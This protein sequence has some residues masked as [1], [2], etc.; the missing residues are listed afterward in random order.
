MSEASSAAPAEQTLEQALAEMKREQAE[1][2]ARETAAR[3]AKV[4]EEQ[5]QLTMDMEEKRHEEKLVAQRKQRD[6]ALR[7][8]N[9]RIASETRLAEQ[10]AEKELWAS[11]AKSAEVQAKFQAFLA[12]GR[13]FPMR[14]PSRGII[15]ELD[16]TPGR[17][18]GPVSYK[19]IVDAGA[20]E[21]FE[22]FL[23][24]MIPTDLNNR[25][26]NDRGMWTD[27][28][29]NAGLRDDYQQRFEDFK[30]LGPIWEETG[31]LKK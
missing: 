9:E 18:A 13:S 10:K 7:A 23:S 3:L 8:E 24:M 2:H 11:R 19:A 17:S 16:R 28:A 12:D 31:L 20:L 27:P 4:T 6:A 30:K 26:R 29:G 22:R 1:R 15:W 21:S 5:H 25:Q 14:H